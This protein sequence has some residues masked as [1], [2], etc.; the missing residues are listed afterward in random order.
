MHNRLSVHALQEH[1]P[2]PSCIIYN[3]YKEEIRPSPS[4]PTSEWEEREKKRERERQKPH[5]KQVLIPCSPAQLLAYYKAPQP[6]TSPDAANDGF[7]LER[8]FSQRSV[9]V[10]YGRM[11]RQRGT[12]RFF[13]W[14]LG[15]PAGGPP[16]PATAPASPFVR[17]RFPSPS[18]PG[19]PAGPMGTFSR[20]SASCGAAGWPSSIPFHSLA[21]CPRFRP[22]PEF[23]PCRRQIFCSRPLRHRAAGEQRTEAG[24]EKNYWKRCCTA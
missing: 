1:R 7:S 13:N 11:V 16:A 22:R 24:E 6:S 15:R 10:W 2:L 14:P 21:A 23:P 4:R 3:R 12:C 17:V 20:P 8:R 19:P 18:R 5:N 9:G